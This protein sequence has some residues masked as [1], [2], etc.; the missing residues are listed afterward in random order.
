L[1]EEEHKENLRKNLKTKSIV[2]YV[3]KPGPRSCPMCKR[4]ADGNWR[5]QKGKW[6]QPI[7]EN[8]RRT[9]EKEESPAF[10]GYCTDPTTGFYIGGIGNDCRFVDL[11]AQRRGARFT[12]L[13]LR[14]RPRSKSLK[15]GTPMKSKIEMIDGYKGRLGVYLSMESALK[16][17]T[18]DLLKKIKLIK[19]DSS[20]EKSIKSIDVYDLPDSEPDVVYYQLEEIKLARLS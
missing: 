9:K 14:K 2:I 8:K 11:E 6:R 7:P 4:K 19:V 20:C 3:E 1:S 15:R 13:L 18:E 10:S 17:E 5:F 16:Y 12:S